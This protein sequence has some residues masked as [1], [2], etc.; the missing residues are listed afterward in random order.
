MLVVSTR[1]FRERQGKYLGMVANGEDVVLKSRKEGS[2]KIVPLQRDDALMSKEEFYAKLDRA[3]QQIKD[4]QLHTLD[5]NSIDEF[6]G[7]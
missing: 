4:G 6:L 1:E 2:F 5:M 3:I 7:L